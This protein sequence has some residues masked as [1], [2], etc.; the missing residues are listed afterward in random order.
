MQR[1]LAVWAKEAPSREAPEQIPEV[2]VADPALQ[3]AHLGTR[4]TLSLSFP[5]ERLNSPSAKILTQRPMSQPSKEKDSPL[6]R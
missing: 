1:A 3:P 4:P 5:T 6:D 2:P